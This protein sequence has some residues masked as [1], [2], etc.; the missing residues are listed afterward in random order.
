MW[1]K[2]LSLFLYSFDAY[3]DFMIVFRCFISLVLYEKSIQG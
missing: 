3:V 2:N 1:K